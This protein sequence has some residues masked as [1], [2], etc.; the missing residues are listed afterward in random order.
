MEIPQA[1]LDK[2]AAMSPVMET[3]ME[4]V[5][6]CPK[7][8]EVSGD[9]P[10]T[11]ALLSTWFKVMCEK[12][13][14]FQC[15]ATEKEACFAEGDAGSYPFLRAAAEVAC[16]CDACPKARWGMS[17]VQGAMTTAIVEGVKY[18]MT[19]VPGKHTAE[20]IATMI[21]TSMCTMADD[22]ECLQTHPEC[23]EVFAPSHMQNFTT[24]DPAKFI[25]LC[26]EKGFATSAPEPSLPAP[27]STLRKFLAGDP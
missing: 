7:E 20:E 9:G 27:T 25:K 18:N 24:V 17:K 8:A 15:L 6:A 11:E 22:M 13:A 10:A 23:K 19:G 4:S 26:A 2:C 5:K 1:C 14:E 12:K 21:E 3:M 16:W